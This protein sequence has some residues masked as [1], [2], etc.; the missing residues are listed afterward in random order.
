[1]IGIE[2]KINIPFD[3]GKLT[4]QVWEKAQDVSNDYKTMVYEDSTDALFIVRF[5][6]EESANKVDDSFYSFATYLNNR[7]LTYEVQAYEG[8]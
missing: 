7:F 5:E 2:I 8:N 1:V 6:H 3:A 4:D